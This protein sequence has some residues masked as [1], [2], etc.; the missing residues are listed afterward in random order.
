MSA[1][2][3]YENLVVEYHNKSGVKRAVDQVSLTVE[4]GEIFAL[5]GPNG[6]GKTSMISA[7]T[8]LIP[9]Q[10]GRI[11][12]LG[13]AAGTPEAK[14]NLG[15]VPQELVGYGF[16]TVN[17]ILNF[18][19]GYFG[20]RNNQ[21]RIDE[22]L[23]R[24]QL[25]NYKHKLVS[26]LSGGLK[27]RMLIAKALAHTP[28]VLLLD[29]PSAGVDVELRA[30]LWDYVLELNRGG[31]TIILTTHYLEEAERL[32]KRTAILDQ[33]KL[34]LLEETQKIIDSSEAGN[35]EKAFLKLLKKV[36][37]A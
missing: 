9:Y 8:S 30:I 34:L 29:E 1:A 31:M 21:A 35:L 7:T 5:L 6:A 25:K 32:C 4:Q 13:C 17:E 23:E 20:I 16:F 27:R 12:I 3:H 24:L 36:Q 22:L 28:K 19:S 14:R 37:K 26:E 15:I 33:G 2:L 11:E 10:G 18:S